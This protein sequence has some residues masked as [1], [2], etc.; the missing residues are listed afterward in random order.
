MTRAMEK[1]RPIHT[2]NSKRKNGKMN[3]SALRTI[4]PRSEGV[5]R[6]PKLSDHVQQKDTPKARRTFHD[7][8][9]SWITLV[10]VDTPETVENPR[11]LSS[12]T[13]EKTKGNATVW[14][15]QSA[16]NTGHNRQ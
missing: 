10:S 15:C 2:R 5:A 9:S 3:R 16:T 13:F 11:R 6:H 7:Q 8:E 14:T 12:N 1:R 4:Q